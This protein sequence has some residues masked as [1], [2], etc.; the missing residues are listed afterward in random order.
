[1]REN[2]LHIK[3]LS[4]GKEVASAIGLY[5]NSFTTPGEIF[6]EFM[7]TKDRNVQHN[8][9]MLCLEWFRTLAN[10]QFGDLRCKA[11]IGYAVTISYH[12]RYESTEKQ[13]IS[14]AGFDKEYDFNY[15]DDSSAAALIEGYLRLSDN[16]NAFI[17]QMLHE[18]KTNIQSFSR[19]CCE[20]FK[21]LEKEPSR[22]K[23][24]VTVA[25]KAAKYYN[26]FP[27]I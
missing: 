7:L 24:C 4:D 19:M 1:M 26:G 27:M 10:Y 17:S 11:S 25:R 9:T 6:Y 21:V 5:V 14:G 23:K 2:T 12:L 18:H 8:F 15:R 16:N 3:N 13:K 20:W 22:Y